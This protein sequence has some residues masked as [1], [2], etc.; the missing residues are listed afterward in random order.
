MA[1]PYLSCE[2][3]YVAITVSINSNGGFTAQV[4][5][6]TG[7][8]TFHPSFAPESEMTSVLVDDGFQLSLSADKTRSQQNGTTVEQSAGDLW[9]RARSGRVSRV[10]LNCTKTF[11]SYTGSI[12]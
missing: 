12:N 5:D 6:A 10:K 8:V 2:G 9:Y 1:S 11:D 7:F 4:L 3:D